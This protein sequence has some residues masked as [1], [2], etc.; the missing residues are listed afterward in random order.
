MKGEPRRPAPH[1]DVT[2]LQPKAARLVAAFQSAKQEDGGQPQGNRDDRSAEVGLVLVLMQRHPRAWLIAIDEARVRQEGF[3][4]GAV[5]RLFRKLAKRSRHGRPGLSR[6]R[7]AAIVTIARAIGHPANAAAVRH[8]HRHLMAARSEHL[9]KRR[10]FEYRPDRRDQIT[11]KWHGEAVQ[12]HGAVSDPLLQRVRGGFEQISG[13]RPT[14]S[15]GIMK[16]HAERMAVPGTDPAYAMAEIDPISS[17]RPLNR[18]H[19]H[20]E[21][22]RIPLSERHHLGPGL[23]ARALLRQYKLAAAEI[24]ARFGQETRN[25]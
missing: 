14:H 6:F 8:G 7:I 11:F 19:M 20:R 25:L 1:D 23:H 10:L 13:Q 15:F 12:K 3:K 24:A 4:A 9:P 16:D 17:A 5:G 21:G 22:H 18:S 2:M